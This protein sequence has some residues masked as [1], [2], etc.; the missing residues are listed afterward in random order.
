MNKGISM[1]EFEKLHIEFD[2]RETPSNSPWQKVTDVLA[3]KTY[4]GKSAK[5]VG[6]M[7]AATYGQIRKDIADGWERLKD[8]G[9]SEEQV[10]NAVT[11]S[12]HKVAERMAKYLEEKEVT[13]AGGLKRLLY[14]AI[15]EKEF[16]EI[17][18]EV[19]KEMD[20][21]KERLAMVKA[22]D[23]KLTRNLEA[24]G[25]RA[26]AVLGI[27]G[28]AYF[29]LKLFK[30]GVQEASAEN[31]SS[32]SA[33]VATAST[34]EVKATELPPTTT[35]F[36]VTRD[37]QVADK[38][39]EERVLGKEPFREGKI[40]FRKPFTVVVPEETAK[41]GGSGEGFEIQVNPLPETKS[42]EWSHLD[43]FLSLWDALSRRSMEI[44]KTDLG[45]TMIVGHTF[46]YDVDGDGVF[47]PLPFNW[48]QKI[49][50][51]KILGQEI[52]IIQEDVEQKYKAIAAV[53]V[54]AWNL[55]AKNEDLWG[56]QA[57]G[58][59]ART[60]KIGLDQELRQIIKERNVFVMV[61]CDDEFSGNPDQHGF[62]RTLIVWERVEFAE[63]WQT[64][65]AGWDEGRGN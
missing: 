13:A 55:S 60:D 45:A 28:M 48:V 3:E 11:M 21:E 37:F 39:V 16:E 62:D 18:V 12:E 23:I 40:D 59:I 42:A 53:K 4:R 54:P 63:E 6:N 7:A 24:W 51:V 26:L 41:V 8:D 43:D 30:S 50:P 57:G 34:L 61:V 20:S 25:T 56:E 33:P 9:W 5:F 22:E 15:G 49:G 27:A 10:E 44:I 35:P 1:T 14:S 19:K 52:P 64:P 38:G 29:A 2:Q 32:Y 36:A 65:G 47:E 17:A 58:F 31:Y 46:Y